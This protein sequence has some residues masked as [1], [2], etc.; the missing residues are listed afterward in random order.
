MG[1][2]VNLCNDE[3]VKKLILII[4]VIILSGLGLAN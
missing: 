2:N 3:R 1:I 4:N